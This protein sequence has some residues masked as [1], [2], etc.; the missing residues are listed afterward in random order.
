MK[1]LIAHKLVRVAPGIRKEVPV[2]QI[3]VDAVETS[4]W[5]LNWDGQFECTHYF[6]NADYEYDLYICAD[7]D[8]VVEDAGSPSQDRGEYRAEVQYEMS[9][10]N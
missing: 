6:T 5:A 1:T 4:P 8:E 3:P 10:G 7:C 9:K 2:Y